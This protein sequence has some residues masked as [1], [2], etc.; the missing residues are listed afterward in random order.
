VAWSFV[1]LALRRVL[2]LVLLC[3]RSAEALPRGALPLGQARPRRLCDYSCPSARLRRLW[4][5]VPASRQSCHSA[6]ISYSH[7]LVCDNLEAIN[8]VGA[9]YSVTSCDLHILMGR[10]TES[11]SPHDPPSR[12]DHS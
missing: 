5:N 7:A 8:P 9:S 2:E 12:H 11:I 10:P 1:Y 6:L 3:F 4:G